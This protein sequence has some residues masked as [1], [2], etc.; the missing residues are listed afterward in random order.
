ML[1]IGLT[2]SIASGKSTI[3]ARLQRHHFP[4]FDSDAAVHDLL[5]PHGKAVPLI[6]SHFGSCGSLDQGIDRPSLGAHVFG[7]KTALADLEAIL[8]PLVAEARNRFL[9][10]AQMARRRAVILD[11]PLLFETKTD[12]LCDV[13]LLAWAPLRLIRQ[14]ALRR[15]H[16]SEAKLDAILAKQMPQ[17]QKERLAD[18]KI[19]TSLGHGVMTAQI[20]RLL[21]KWRLYH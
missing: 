2:G 7:D 15:P 20:L 17:S 5:G 16:M 8:H 9:Q 6:L 11:V 3:A 14:R 10:Q 18:E 12:L 4:V 1:I 19:I 21:S 13:T